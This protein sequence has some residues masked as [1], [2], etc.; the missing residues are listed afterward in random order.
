MTR[1]GA[2]SHLRI[3][4]NEIGDLLG[5][6]R[7]ADVV[8]AKT[9]VEVGEIGNVVTVFETGLMIRMVM[10]VRAEAAGFLVKILEL[11]FRRGFRQRE[12]RQHA[13][14]FFI[15][16]IDD[17]RHVQILIA[18]FADRLVVDQ[19]DFAPRQRQVCMNS[20]RSGN[21]AKCDLADQLRL[22]K[23]RNIENDAAAV[24]VG[25][26]SSVAFDVRRTMAGKFQIV[27][28]RAFFL[29]R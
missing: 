5:L 18:V 29:L 14:A 23:I 28:W 21:P 3:A 17:P 8:D 24:A 4:G 10:V 7:I 25:K 12:E 22:R 6:A 13:R 15:A 2:D 1:L 9:G 16:D 26:I 27:C 11:A 19:S 20:L